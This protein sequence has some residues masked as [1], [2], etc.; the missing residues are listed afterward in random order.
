MKLVLKVQ[1][2]TNVAE[3]EMKQKDVVILGRGSNASHKLVDGKLSNAHCRLV[4]MSD[5][6]MVY[7][8]GSKNGTTVNGIKVMEAAEVYIGDEIIV[9]ETKITMHTARMDKETVAALTFKGNP[10]DRNGKNLRLDY[11]A[12]F[13]KPK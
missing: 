1:T 13:K 5:K 11:T 3:L 6:L 10:L 8:L 12:V 4:L 9:G 7:D 2:G